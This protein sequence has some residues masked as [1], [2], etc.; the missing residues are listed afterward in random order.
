MAKFNRTFNQSVWVNHLTRNYV[1]SGK[2]SE[3]IKNGITGV[4]FNQISF[5]LD[6][7]SG[8]YSF[9]ERENDIEDS[10]D[11]YEQLVCKDICDAAK[12]L[13]SVYENTNTNDGY[14]CLEVDPA[15]AN[16]VDAM[17]LSSSDL[18]YNLINLPNFM[19]KIPGTKSGIKVLEKLIRDGEN[20]NVGAIYSVEQYEKVALAYIESLK[21]RLADNLPLDEIN[22]VVSVPVYPM[23]YTIDGFLG[24]NDY[25][26]DT[27][28]LNARLIYAKYEEIFGSIDFVRLRHKGANTQRIAWVLNGLETTRYSR[29][30]PVNDTILVA[31]LNDLELNNFAD[32][33]INRSVYDADVYFEGL[34]KIGVNRKNNWKKIADDL[35]KIEISNSLE[36]F[37]DVMGIIYEKFCC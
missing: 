37:D 25:I 33:R 8:Q 27:A 35:Q 1:T 36:I 11:I 6:I 31:S 34:E 20:V 22:S 16:R 7:E 3:H 19:I 18:I 12:L 26:R 24:T 17:H 13:N 4:V 14:V 23:D 9:F 10:I 30:L 32:N 21:E 2:L 29:N 28:V 15:F 5:Y